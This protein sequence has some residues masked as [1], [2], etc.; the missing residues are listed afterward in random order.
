MTG[1]PPVG[2][3][4]QEYREGSWGPGGP[5]VAFKYGLYTSLELVTPKAPTWT[6]KDGFTLPEVEGVE[7]SENGTN[8]REVTAEPEEAYAFPADAKT[9]WTV[10]EPNCSGNQDVLAESGFDVHPGVI[11]AG[12]AALGLGIIL[13]RR[14]A[15]G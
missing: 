3:P 13:R 2:L 15:R 8:P 10:R 7:Y 14:A 9:E 12:V 5:N 6:C 4:Y 11:V 1:L